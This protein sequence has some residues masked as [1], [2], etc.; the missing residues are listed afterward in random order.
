VTAPVLL[1][2]LVARMQLASLPEIA[3]S[4][5]WLL[6]AR[7]LQNQVL[8]QDAPRLTQLLAAGLPNASVDGRSETWE[9]LAQ[10][11]SGA[12]GPTAADSAVVIK[13]RKALA[14]LLPAAAELVSSAVSGRDDFLIIDVLDA[15][16]SFARGPDRDTVVDALRSFSMRGPAEERRVNV[17]L[18]RD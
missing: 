12:C 7:V 2:D 16:L 17:A 1:E 14:E 4:A 5:R 6:E 9:L 11:A 18:G 10:L 15:M 8:G 13:V 3:E